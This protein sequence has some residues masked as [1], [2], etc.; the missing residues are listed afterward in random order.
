MYFI[1][2]KKNNYE[3]EIFEMLKSFI[4]KIEIK[5][6]NDYVLIRHNYKNK[7][8]IIRSIETLSSD[9]MYQICAYV[10]SYSDDEEKELEIIKP[11]MENVISDIYDFKKIIIYNEN[12]INDKS[13]ILN[14]ILKGTGID[15]EFI[16]NF[17][18]VNLNVSKA[19]SVMYLHRN[20]ILYKLNKLI[21]I[22][23]F[24]LRVFND[25]YILYSL[26]EYK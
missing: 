7:L 9:L 6:E 2:I 14:F 23:D 1:L 26:L 10:S 20:T 16:S 19:S 17:C 24:D 18:K 25:A 13:K 21:E 22:R 5:E 12:K 3:N 15:T 4:P 11:L 8:D